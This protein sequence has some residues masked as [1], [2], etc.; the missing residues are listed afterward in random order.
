MKIFVTFILMVTSV[1]CA[2][3]AISPFWSVTSAAAQ[4]TSSLTIQPGTGR[5]GIGT[6]APGTT[7]DVAG[8]VRAS[9]A[10]NAGTVSAP[11]MW[12]VIANTTLGA[13]APS[14]DITGI[15]TTYTMLKLAFSLANTDVA[16]RWVWIRF[17]GDVGASYSRI[18]KGLWSPCDLGEN[19][20][21]AGLLTHVV[22]AA[23][24]VYWTTGE[25]LINN[26]ASQR[27]QVTGFSADHYPGIIACMGLTNSTWN[28]TLSSISR[29]TLFIDAGSFPAGSRVT[30]YGSY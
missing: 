17:N 7:L 12:V 23:S 3:T 18:Y 6:A 22:R 13:Q 19:N 1:I 28:N 29:I 5:V 27:K 26:V 15:P 30:L 24:P 4:V 11:G 8:D 16:D 21:T 10:I 20:Q 2:V 14:I 25:V 9:G